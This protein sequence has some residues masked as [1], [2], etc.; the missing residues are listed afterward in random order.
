ML[1][2]NNIGKSSVTGQHGKKAADMW[3]R[4][5]L[6]Y[7]KGRI[8]RSLS[9]GAPLSS[10]LNRAVEALAGAYRQI[11][12]WQRALQVLS[13]YRFVFG[14]SWVADAAPASLLVAKEAVV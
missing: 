3:I 1:N 5:A 13:R 8:S 14:H 2:S 9:E 6:L 12:S 11:S 7:V 10:S 4:Y